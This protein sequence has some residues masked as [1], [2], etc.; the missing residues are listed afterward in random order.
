MDQNP[1]RVS[2]VRYLALRLAAWGDDHR[3]AVGLV[4]VLL[5]L[6]AS[7]WF[8]YLI[9]LGGAQHVRHVAN[10]TWFRIFGGQQRIEKAINIY[11][12][13]YT[14]GSSSYDRMDIKGI[15][16]YVTGRNFEASLRNRLR[17]P[18][19]LI[20]ILVLD[21]SVALAPE[22]TEKGRA[23]ASLARAYGQE[24]V[25]LRA[26]VLHSSVVL[27]QLAAN[28]GTRCEVRVFSEPSATSSL[29]HWTSS[30]SYQQW[31]SENPSRRL[32][33]VV[34]CPRNE[35]P[36]DSPSGSAWRIGNRPNHDLTIGASKEFIELWTKPGTVPLKSVMQRVNKVLGGYGE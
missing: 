18:H 15:S 26:E 4:S 5:L 1:Q 2:P 7:A 24:P 14:F 34:P 25:E 17:A 36:T 28:L 33:I 31:M 10:L 35:Q 12:E 19:A 11:E 20:R 23:F 29:P 9:G 22:H 8:T 16:L 3:V 27:D 21:P 6:L 30:R 13:I 32:D